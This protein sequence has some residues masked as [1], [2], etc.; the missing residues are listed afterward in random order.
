[1]VLWPQS[2]LIKCNII[3]KSANKNKNITNRRRQ[4]VFI[5]TCKQASTFFLPLAA[6]THFICTQVTRT[7]NNMYTYYT[8]IRNGRVFS[9]NNMK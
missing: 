2:R 3:D 4:K 9:M 8:A 7:R 1:M 6:E 5:E